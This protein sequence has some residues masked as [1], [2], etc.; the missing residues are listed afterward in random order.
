MN[1]QLIGKDEKGCELPGEVNS[2][3][4]LSFFPDYS[5]WKNFLPKVCSQAHLR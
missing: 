1:E 4:E 3:L 2:K 5:L